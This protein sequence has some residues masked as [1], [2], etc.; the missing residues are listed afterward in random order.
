MSAGRPVRVERLGLVEYDEAL[1][2][3]HDRAGRVRAG[4]PET[5]AL[6]EHPPVYTLGMRGDPAHVLAPAEWLAARGARVVRT[7]RGGDV[8][9][10]GPGQLVI[11]AI[12][13]LRARGLGPADYIRALESCVIATANGC[14]VEAART[15][16]RPGVWVGGAKI[17]AVG[18]RIRGGVSMHGL[19][20]N[21]A[22]DLGWFDAIVPCGI[23][24]AGVTSLARELG[25]ACPPA[26]EV[27]S[28][29][30]DAFAAT[31]AAN[32]VTMAGVC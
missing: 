5:V 1:A 28:A 23:A 13:D 8:T 22:T 3:Q 31:F 32:L 16:G 20:L 4:E 14:G 17:A 7:D 24:D 26:E 27:A 10:H 21:V 12:L 15:P 18:V 6:L 9:F 11:Y 29:F 19:A 2:W 25:G 30:L